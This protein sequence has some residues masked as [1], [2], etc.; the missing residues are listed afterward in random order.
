MGVFA[1]SM[2]VAA[3]GGGG[4][5]GS[6]D[7]GSAP[8]GIGLEDLNLDGRV[9]I[10]CFGDSITRGVGDGPSAESTPPAPAGYPA[11]LQPLLAP[12]TTLP[13]DV[14]DGGRAGERTNTGVS[15]LQRDVP[16]NQPDYVILLEGSNDVEDGHTQDA[17]GNMQRMIDAVFANGAMP[18]LGTI[19][20]TCCAHKNQLPEGAILAYNNQLRAMAFNNSIPV[21][22][23][24]AELA[25][26]P[27]AEYDSTLGL[28]HIPE[29]LHP[30]PAGYDLMALAAQ[31]VF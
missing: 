10:L 30:T 4:G 22:D 21:I 28:I 7:G 16:L 13:L 2:A 11:R 3:C 5:G 17:L 1:L 24:Y 29:G 31:E 15:R 9:R 26:G 6:D 12:E 25:G 27:Q 18:L 20:P 19:T 23:F 8:R 14:I